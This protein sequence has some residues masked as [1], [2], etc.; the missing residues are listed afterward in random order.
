MNMNG[1]ESQ[2]RQEPL[3]RRWQEITSVP[4][5]SQFPRPTS[6]LPNFMTKPITFP[7]F[8]DDDLVS[9]MI[10][11]VTVVLE[12]RSICQRISLQKHANYHSLAKALRQ[13]FVDGGSDSGGSTA[14]S[15]SESVSDHDLDLTNAVPGHLIA[16]EDIESD[17]LL[18]GD[19][20]WKDFVRVAKRIRIL[21]AKGNSRKR[22]GGAA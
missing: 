5:L 12:G 10:P 1:F 19:L 6:S 13:M 18:A 7:G 17:L 11:P 3:K 14:S 9:T 20:N 16:Y 15:A 21:P 4:N 8:E 22:T 2:Q